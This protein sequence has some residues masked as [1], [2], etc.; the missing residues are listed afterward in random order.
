MPFFQTL[1]THFPGAIPETDFV[2][3]TYDAL[4]EMGFNH[5]NTLACVGVCRDEITRS[6]VEGVQQTWGDVFDASGLGGLL[7]MGKTGFSAAHHHAPVKAGRERCLY[8]HMAHI[9][10]DGD[11]EIGVCHRPGRPDASGACGAL[12]AFRQEMLGGS[13][14]LALDP[15]DIEQSLLKQ[16]LYP[17]IGI[18]NVPDLISLTKIAY[19]AILE[20]LEAMIRETVDTAHSD[21]AVLTGVQIH[22]ANNQQYVWPGEM[23]AVING[24]RKTIELT[25]N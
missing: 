3:L 9:A 15:D 23:Y 2:L 25:A 19:E 21:Y 6:L 13:L 24:Q 7:F 22:G 18:G 5:E 12:L 10:I 20:D 17:R 8:V 14:S 16:R 1:D 11:G 4:S